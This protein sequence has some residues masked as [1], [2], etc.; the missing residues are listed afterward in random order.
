M[1]DAMQFLE[2]VLPDAGLYCLY[3]HPLTAPRGKHKLVHN[4]SEIL[5]AV[6][7]N[8]H[9][10]DVYFAVHTLRERRIWNVHKQGPLPSDAP[11]GA[12]KGGW[13]IRTHAN[14]LEAKAVYLDLDVGKADGYATQRD[15]LID[16]RRF[17]DETGLPKPTIVSSGH[18]V[19]VYWTLVRSVDSALTWLTMASHLKALCWTLGLRTDQSVTADRARIL[20]PVGSINHKRGQ[21]AAVKALA[22]GAPNDPDALLL[23]LTNASA[24]HGSTPDPI[25]TVSG[26][27]GAST[28]DASA[29][30]GRTFDGALAPLEDVLTACAQIRRM[31][32][33]PAS[34]S[35]PEWYAALGVVVHTAEGVEAAH[36]IS[37]GHPGYDHAET[38]AKAE[39]AAALPPTGCPKIRSVSG[40]HA[41]LCDGCKFWG[42]TKGPMTAS[43][44]AAP[45]APAPRLLLRTSEDVVEEIVAPDPPQPYK[46][47][48]DGWI[49]MHSQTKEGQ[50]ILIPIVGGDLYPV[51]RMREANGPDMQKWRYHP[52]NGEGVRDFTVQGSTFVDA[53]K[54]IG[55][56]ADQGIY[57]EDPKK[58]GHYMSFYLRHLAS[59]HKAAPQH[60]A[61]GW[62][63]GYESFVLGAKMI[64]PDGV[65]PALLNGDAS[66]VS[67]PLHARG[68]LE[69]QVEALRFYDDP[70][71]V[72][73]Q[74]YIAASAAAPWLYITRQLGLVINAVGAGG[75]SKST[76]LRA[77]ASVWGDPANFIQSGLSHSHTRRG[78]DLY[79]ASLSNLPVCIDEISLMG[80]HEARAFVMGVSQKGAG[81]KSDRSGHLREMVESRKHSVFLTNSNRSLID[82]TSAQDDDIAG[83]AAMRVLEIPFA[84]LD[85]HS[86]AEADAFIAQIM[87]NYGHV[88]PLLMRELVPR[89]ER[90]ERAIFQRML[91]VD[92][93]LGL[94][95]AERFR[96]ASFATTLMTI[97]FMRS[98]GLVGWS[99][100]EALEWLR[101]TQ[102]NHMR[103]LDERVQI[104]SDPVS[105]LSDYFGANHG[106]TV[107]VQGGAANAVWTELEPNGRLEVHYD[108]PSKTIWVSR[109]GLRTYCTRRGVNANALV[110]D[111]VSRGVVTQDD[112][113]FTLGHGTKH[114]I[115][116]SRCVKIDASHPEIAAAA[117]QKPGIPLASATVTPFRRP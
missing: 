76:T 113:R 95:S 90:V 42:R 35:E 10:A 40:A 51:M 20:R 36:E 37:R 26:A 53:S 52:R 104:Q 47:M 114:G 61:L 59:R 17:C 93:A 83:A 70:R 106:A 101:A 84:G 66:V 27:S 39:R 34:V 98:V 64:A 80:E 108:I 60:A 89:R 8:K 16:L 109:N 68:T 54:L 100:D 111:L 25:S 28:G 57:V 58:L 112:V 43:R 86:K 41:G 96:S 77:A 24:T 15:A 38:Q 49:V 11:A 82:M 73:R 115:A 6:D 5:Q 99:S 12:T 19:H 97:D 103:R 50:D 55:I 107:I 72:A 7:A 88:G 116:R 1:P 74:F 31:A 105:V 78:L 22:W 29:L 75:T 14:A 117:P 92:K 44:L 79:A 30:E 102:L 48:K 85:V 23:A 46:R 63:A 45:S 91:Q 71:Y 18:G 87:E 13:S 9:K 69:A 94:T 4:F 3:I 110:A 2:S 81:P 32:D 56:V 21:K 33:D 62:T 65:K 67:A